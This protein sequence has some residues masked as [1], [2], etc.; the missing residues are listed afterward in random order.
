MTKIA[1]PVKGRAVFAHPVI[2]KVIKHYIKMEIFQN[3]FVGKDI[4][5]IRDNAR[6]VTIHVTVVLIRKKILVFLAIQTNIVSS[7]TNPVKMVPKSDNVRAKRD[8]PKT[9]N[10]IF[11]VS[12]LLKF[13]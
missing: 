8:I 13:Q 7:R 6:L 11:Y 1:G 3:V 4:L 5:K 12:L 10:L 9:P 2:Y